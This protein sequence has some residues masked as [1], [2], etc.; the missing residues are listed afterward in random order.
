MKTKTDLE[1]LKDLEKELGRRIY[2]I[3]LENFENARQHSFAV[4]EKGNVVGLFLIGIELDPVPAVLPQFCHLKKL[5]L[6]ACKLKD[7]SFLQGLSNLTDLD[8]RGNQ[9]TDISFL[10]GLDNLT[11][12][13]LMY[14]QIT[15]ISP[16]QGL[17]RLE[18]V[19]L[20]HNKIRQLPEAI[21]E[22][23]LKLDVD[24]NEARFDDKK[25]H[26][27]DNPLETPP[28]E[29]IRK[30]KK[31]IRAYFASL[32]EE[33]LPLNEVKVLLVGD[34]GAGKTS[35][36]KQLLV[37]AFNKKE[38]KTDGI[39][40]NYWY[41]SAN[42][43]STKT[44]VNL[45]D[46]G[47]QEVMHAT[48][49]F[50]L[51]RRSLYILVLDGRRDE[52]TEY[53]LNHIK[54]FG[55]ASPVIIVLNKI[56]QTPGFDVN[57]LFLQ[58]KYPN[59]K[60]FYRISCATKEGIKEFTG[61]LTRELFTVEHIRSQWAASWFKVKKRL[62]TMSQHYISLQEYENLCAEEKITGDTA[63]Q[64]LLE[65]L[66]DLGVALHFPELTL[67][68]THVLD[69]Q[70]I[71]NAVYKIINSPLLSDCK[72]ILKLSLLD[73]ILAP[74]DKKDYV[75]PRDKYSFIID[76][77]RKFEL[78]FELDEQRVL[79]PELLGIGQPPLDFDF[80]RSLKFQVYYEFLPRSVMPRF[81]VK[82]HK[83]IKGDLRWRTGV[84]LEN[85]DFA[86]AAVVKEDERDRRIYIDVIGTNK[87]D[88]LATI[89]HTLREIHTGFA[90]F[91]K[92]AP[93]ERVPLPDNPA[94]TVGY[95]HLLRLET[96]KEL[97]LV[98]EG[99]D[100]PYNVTELLDGIK[101]PE[102]RRKDA[103]KMLGERNIILSITPT[104]VTDLKLLQ[105]Q[106][107]RQEVAV[108]VDVE[109]NIELSIE[110]PALQADFDDLK[111]LLIRLNPELEKKLTELGESLDQLSPKSKPAEL[112]APMN[113]L[114][115]FLKKLGDEKSDLNK[116]LGGAKKGVA[117]LQKVGKTYNKIAQWLA[118]PQVP[119]LLL[120]KI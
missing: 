115:R 27:W 66:H 42:Q 60:G 86:A 45:W 99:A 92:I 61:A 107:N 47:G 79:V 26:L 80:D 29:I 94:V 55:G 17:T 53:W 5:R 10:Q 56:D 67:T 101:P 70:W 91:D 36:A 90:G 76:L 82:R 84:V 85:R 95:R 71:T 117:T 57:R 69:P 100:R 106:Q 19:I 23:G 110:I 3:S 62:E 105:I 50:F 43:D 2:E 41:I 87:R 16:L 111:E 89:I 109:V 113:K 102:E 20:W 39:N 49:Q 93:D 14:N 74:K 59:I 13:N 33:T 12:L 15:D 103:E 48:H 22:L 54:S 65:F 120:K 73:K 118:L 51:S 98:P 32:K 96:M 63:R 11:H 72:G 24:S 18:D 38:A 9:I 78:C 34:G 30:G 40:I 81:I 68:G 28:P 21:V 31:A 8:L 7:I 25:L 83:E 37:K 116:I 97:S 46:F 35:L 1:L 58:N 77:M 112:N 88:Y 119:D 114:G 4:D 64:T 108:D 44:K 75:Y 104:Q 52:K 6:L